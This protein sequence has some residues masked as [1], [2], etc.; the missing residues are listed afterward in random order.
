MGQKSASKANRDGVAE[1]FPAPAVQKSLAGDLALIDHDDHL[2]R[3]RA[4]VMLK[5]AK[6]HEAHT[7][8]LLRT[9]PGS[10]AILR[11]VLRSAIQ[12]IQRFP[13]LQD[14]VS[15]CRLVTCAKA[16]AGKRSGTSGTQSGNASLQWAFSEAA[17]LCL[18][19]HPQGQTYLARVEKKPGK[20]QA[21][22]VPAPKRARAVSYR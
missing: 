4:L 17:V 3:D 16:S 9:V 18:R 19:H 7:R 15:S 22:T 14:V 5:T 13:R 10:G 11:L 6:Q 12:D 21:L 1:R 20:G 2:L 8:S